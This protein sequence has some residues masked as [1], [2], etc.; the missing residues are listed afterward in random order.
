MVLGTLIALL[1]VQR[2]RADADRSSRAALV[3]AWAMPVVVAV[4]L[5]YWM[6]NYEN[7]VLNYVL[8][9]LGVGD[10]LQHDWYANPT[11]GARRDT[12]LIVWG[13]IPFVAITVYAGLAQVPGELLEAAEIDGAGALRSASAT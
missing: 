8:T 5:W 3:L 13:A 7:G 12:S 1:L 11:L 6:T 9:K 10:F 2:Q 4:Q